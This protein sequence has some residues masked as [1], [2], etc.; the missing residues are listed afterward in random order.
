MGT[1]FRVL[2]ILFKILIN[3]ITYQPLFQTRAQR[4]LTKKE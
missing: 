3:V 1:I 2:F 4:Y